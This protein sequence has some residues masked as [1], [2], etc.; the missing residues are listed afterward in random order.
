MVLASASLLAAACG[1]SAKKAD[2]ATTTTAGKTATTAAPATTTTA[3]AT[4]TA[5]PKPATTPAP[6][7]PLGTPTKATGEP[8]LLGY[9]WSGV[10]AAVDNTPDEQTAQ[11]TVKYLNE[12]RGGIG[13]RP[14]KLSI[15][16]G[17]DTATASACGDQFVAD[18]VTAVLMNVQ[19]DIKPWATKVIAAKIPIIAYSSADASLLAPGVDA[20]SLSNPVAGIA[21]FP[22]GVA[23][24]LGAKKAAVSVINVPAAVGPVEKLAKA[25]YA[26]GGTELNVV[27]I[28]PDAADHTSA[29]QEAL[30]GNPETFHIIGNPAYCTNTIKALKTAGYKGQITM[31]SNCLDPAAIKTLGADLKGIQ[32]SYAS[33]E[34]PADPDTILLKAILKKYSEKTAP[35][36][37]AVG[38]FLVWE[39]FARVMKGATDLTSTG[40]VTRMRATDG[41]IGVPTMKGSFIKCDGKQVPG[42]AIAC[43]SGYLVGTLDDKGVPAAFSPPS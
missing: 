18:K 17:S 40:I 34:D 9:S 19:G 28:A 1:S 31:I 38:G 25:I 22:A 7:D 36:G 24:K 8:I 43:V 42:V 29:I 5:A 32:T 14:I 21:F 16:A 3:A 33:G 6:A 11:A 27:A 35:Q 10:S 15:C 26:A 39:G 41:T 13:G 30:Q 37:T 12:Y 4:T 2:P 23:K 20:F